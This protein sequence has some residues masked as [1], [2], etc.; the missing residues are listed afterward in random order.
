[1]KKNILLFTFLFSMLSFGQDSSNYTVIDNKMAKIPANSCGSITEIANYINHNFNTDNDKVRAAFYWTAANIE[2]DVKNMLTD[3][4]TESPEEKIANTLRT[5]KGVCIHYA[6]VFNG[7][8]A[9]IGIQSRIIEGYNQQY[10]KV[11]SL[12]HAWCAAKIENSWYLF[13]PTWGAGHLNN[14]KYVK[15]INNTYFKANPNKIIASHMPFDYLWQFLNYPITNKEFYEGKIQ[16]NKTKAYFDF[17]AEIDRYD[18][19]SEIDKLTESIK[20]IEK[21]GVKNKL[22]QD[23]LTHEKKGL[24]VEKHNTAVEKLNTIADQYNQAIALLNDFISYRNNKFKPTLPDAEISL[25]IQKPK[26]ILE[27]CQNK[28]ELIFGVNSENKAN[29]SSLKKSINETLAQTEEQEKFVI[30]YLGKSKMARKLMFTQVSW[31]GIPLN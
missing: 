27:D 22:I 3:N 26:T 20:R 23:Y 24:E 5:R 25:M 19:Q 15:K 13:D 17:K 14:G 7:I 12:A 11:L 16:I 2:Y 4:S 10:G 8:C 30:T 21:N 31:F 28:I 18:S 1:M 9:K 29:L 6:E